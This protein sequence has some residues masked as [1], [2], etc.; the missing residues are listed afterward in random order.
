MQLI[1]TANAADLKIQTLLKFIQNYPK[2]VSF[3]HISVL[4]VQLCTAFYSFTDCAIFTARFS[5]R[6]QTLNKPYSKKKKK[7]RKKRNRKKEK[8]YS[9]ES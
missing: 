8:M 7:E 3:L 5:V 4:F 9:I 2:S 1:Q 6:R